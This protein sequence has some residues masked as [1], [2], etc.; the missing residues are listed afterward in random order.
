[1]REL[2]RCDHAPYSSATLI[3]LLQLQGDGES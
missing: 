3:S 2:V 1:M